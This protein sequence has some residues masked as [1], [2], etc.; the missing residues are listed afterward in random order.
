M[1]HEP[2]VTI[3]TVVPETV[4]TLVVLEENATVSDE[5]AVALTLIGV[6]DHVCVA[7]PANEMVWEALLMVKVCETLVAAL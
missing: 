5:V 2:D 3:V 7:G 1:V 4:Q 6:A